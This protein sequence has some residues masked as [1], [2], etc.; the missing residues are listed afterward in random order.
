MT[1]DRSEVERIARLAH[2]RF[3]D[4]QADRLTDEMN[5]ILD[6]ASLLRDEGSGDHGVQPRQSDPSTEAGVAGYADGGGLSGAR[7]DE[8]MAPDPLRAPLESVAPRY[9][10]G[11]FVVPPPPGV[12]Q[13]P[14]PEGADESL[15][16]GAREV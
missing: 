4:D 14:G 8:A 15:D 1:V 2:L 3:E 7:A 6:H 11:F 16:P 10:E 13:G 5:R 9:A 12:S